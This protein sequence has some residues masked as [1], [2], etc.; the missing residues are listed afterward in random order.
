MRIEYDREADAVYVQV[1]EGEHAR[2]VEVEPLQIYVDVDV[3]GRTMGV[4]FLSWEIFR[5][6]MNEHAGLNL[7]ERFTGPQSLALT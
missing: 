3:E 5:R 2:T 7:P 4:E 6:Y 1:F